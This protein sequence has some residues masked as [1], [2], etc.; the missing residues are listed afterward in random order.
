MNSNMC[1]IYNS[2]AMM[3]YYG[4]LLVVVCVDEVVGKN[5]FSQTC[6]LNSINDTLHRILLLIWIHSFLKLFIV[7]FKDHHIVVSVTVALQELVV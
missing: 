3:E 6:E 5:D 4:I 2:F 1:L 7:Y